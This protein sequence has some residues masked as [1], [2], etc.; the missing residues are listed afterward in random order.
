MVPRD[1]Q[2]RE[3]DPAQEVPCGGKLAVP[4][5]LGYVPAD[6]DEGGF[7]AREVVYQGIGNPGVHSA[8]MEIGKMGDLAH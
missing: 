5:P 3:R 2:L 4:G 6:G 1:R 8:E 7:E